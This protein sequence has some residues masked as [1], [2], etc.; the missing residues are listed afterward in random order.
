MPCLPRLQDFNDANLQSKLD[1]VN[2][3][4]DMVLSALN[5]A[6]GS[7]VPAPP[8]NYAWVAGPVVGGVV[9]ACAVLAAVIIRRRRRLTKLEPRGRVS[10]AG[11]WVAVQPATELPTLFTAALFSEHMHRAHSFSKRVGIISPCN[12]CCMLLT[13]GGPC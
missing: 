4:A 11:F 3:N 12:T 13:A 9:L 8:A 2:I 5:Q 10:N 6:L 1:A 7:S